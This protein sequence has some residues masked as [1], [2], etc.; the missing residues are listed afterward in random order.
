M[1]DFLY[2]G[3]ACKFSPVHLRYPVTTYDYGA[4]QNGIYFIQT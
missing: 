3:Y 2:R 4:Y 1:R